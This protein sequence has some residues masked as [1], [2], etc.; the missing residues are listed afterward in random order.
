MGEWKIRSQGAV[1]DKNMG[2][3]NSQRI[4][5]CMSIML[6]TQKAEVRGSQVQG[7]LR[8]HSET[9]YQHEI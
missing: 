8:Q 9:L 2:N 5:Q 1:F 4:Q 6:P 7:Q 3:T